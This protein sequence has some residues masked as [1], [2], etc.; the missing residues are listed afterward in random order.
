LGFDFIVRFRGTVTV[1]DA[2]G[3]VRSA[4]EWVPAN[5]QVRPLRHATVTQAFYPLDAV[6]C[7]KARQ[8]KEPWGLAV[9]GPL[10]PGAAVVKLYA[11]RF[12]IE[13]TFRDTQDLRY[14]LG[15]SAT[16][17]RDVHRRDRGRTR[18]S[19]RAARTTP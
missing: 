17:I 1:P 19:V 8:M 3:D 6:V 12:T 5:G 18:C 9:R 2:A 15:L 10:R 14:G 11:R 4:V 16:H 13:E 7:V